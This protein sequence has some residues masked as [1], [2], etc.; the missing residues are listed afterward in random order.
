MPGRA[1]FTVAITK[2]D[3]TNRAL[4]DE[5]VHELATREPDLPIIPVHN[6]PNSVR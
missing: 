4:V 6:H 5:L 3:P 2:V 1:R